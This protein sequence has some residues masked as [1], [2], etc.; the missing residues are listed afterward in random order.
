[1]AGGKETPRQKMIGMMYLVLTALL[2]LQVSNT[3]LEKFIFINRSLENTVTE[4]NAGNTDVV[5]RIQKQVDDAGK[6]KAD[7]AVLDKAREVRERTQKVIA[8]LNAAKAT[9]V[10]ETG[11]VDEDGVTPKNINDEEVT[12]NIMI[13]KGKG[14]EMKTMLND[15]AKFLQ[16]T[17]GVK[18]EP[19]AYSGAEHP[20]FANDPNQKRKSFAELNFGSTPLVAGLATITQFET[21]VLMREQA[22]LDELARSVGA[23]DVK[24][25]RIVPMVRPESKV[26]AAGA[27]Y[28]ADMFIA[29]SSSNI[30][31]DMYVNGNKI[32][33]TGG[34]GKVEFAAKPGAYNEEGLSRQ[35]YKAEIKVTLP[36][37]RDTTYTET[38]EYFVAK[39]VIQVQSASVQ[40]LYLQCGNELNVQVP[41]LGNAYQPNFSADGAAVYEGNKRGVVTVVPNAKNVKLNVSSGGNLIGSEN[42]GVRL[43]PK[44]ELF[45]TDGARE[46]DQKQGIKAAQLGR[47]VMRAEADASFKEFLPKDARFRVTGYTVYLARGNRPVANQKVSGPEFNLSQWRSQAKAG[48]RLVIEVTEVKRMNFRDQVM[49]VSMGTKTFTIPIAD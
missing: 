30:T 41:A 11:G 15:Y 14:E 10:T 49:D 44:P 27:K 16:Q 5:S 26:V 22:V 7:V 18:V 47:L 28:V 4:S 2:A 35:T 36:G 20:I 6:R 12:A 24:F 17:S 31:P 32:P 45:P 3:V 48:D 43:V 33:V 1:M 42:F 21:E 8:E 37:G 25:D 29:A 34:F 40:A 13:V 46:L 38:H 9:L 39:P 23:E 19:I